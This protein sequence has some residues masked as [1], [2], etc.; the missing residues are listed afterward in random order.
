MCVCACVHMN[1]GMHGG[2]KRTSD[3]VELELTS[4]CKLCDM[5]PRN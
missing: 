4:S 5:G 2:K 3:T 1:A